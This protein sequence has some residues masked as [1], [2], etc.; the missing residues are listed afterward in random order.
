MSA[1]YDILMMDAELFI[2]WLV[3]VAQFLFFREACMHDYKI[4]EVEIR[5]FTK[6]LENLKETVPFNI[7]YA[8]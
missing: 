4:I 3:Y 8:T 7:K 6:Q 2:T 5:L 1:I